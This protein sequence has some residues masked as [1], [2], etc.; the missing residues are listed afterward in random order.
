M[1]ASLK[2]AIDDLDRVRAWTR[3][4]GMVNV[5]PGFVDTPWHARGMDAAR[6]ERVVAT[7][8]AGTPLQAVTGPD[9]VAEPIVWLLE[10]ARHVTGETLH[11]DAGLHLRMGQFG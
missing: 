1:L 11:V 6:L 3:A 10:Q 8:R 5:A 9:D 7:V 4:F 2:R